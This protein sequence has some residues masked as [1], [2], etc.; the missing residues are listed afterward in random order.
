VSGLGSDSNAPNCV[1]TAPC[2]TFQAAHDNTIDKG[3]I[4][5]LDPG[6][7]GAVTITKNISIIND[8]VGEAGVLVSGGGTGVT[9]SA[10]NTAAVTL[11]G[12]SIKGI[13]FGGGN[14]IVVNSAAQLNVENSTVRN[15]DGSGVGNG[16][17]VLPNNTTVDLAV[18]NTVISD[19]ALSGILINPTGTSPQVT[20]ILDHVGL[21]NNSLGLFANGDNGGGGFVGVVVND[22]VGSKNG[23]AFGAESS[24]TGTNTTGIVVFV[25]RSVATFN[26]TGILA[27]GTRASAVANGSAIVNN[28]SDGW[29]GNVFSYGNNALFGNGGNQP[30]QPLNLQ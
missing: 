10:P 15:L 2:R 8:G 9:V 16:I 23:T 28:T 7:Y 3:E 4:T 18:T 26:T 25:N 11:R 14:G 13:G 17:V 24:P 5:V 27:R 29:S 22:S 6:S 19:N 20:A 1:R 12:L 21:Y 30:A